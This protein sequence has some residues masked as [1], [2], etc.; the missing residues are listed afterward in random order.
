MPSTTYH[1]EPFRKSSGAVVMSVQISV[2]RSFHVPRAEFRFWM[3]QLSLSV[4]IHPLPGKRKIYPPVI[5]VRIS[6]VNVMTM[7]PA[8]VRIPLARWLAS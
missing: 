1:M 3:I 2:M 7:P 5:R 8:T 6:F 4:V